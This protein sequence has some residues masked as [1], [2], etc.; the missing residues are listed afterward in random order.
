VPT[1]STRNKRCPSKTVNISWLFLFILW[2]IRYFLKIN[3]RISGLE[4]SGTVLPIRG[5]T[6]LF[7]DFT[8][9][10]DKGQ[11]EMAREKSIGIT[12]LFFGSN[13]CGY[14]NIKERGQRYT[15]KV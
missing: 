8:T 9:I 4:I 10:G 13:N 5:F 7:D 1:S 15:T 12:R 6:G 3:S 11:E 2:T 14:N